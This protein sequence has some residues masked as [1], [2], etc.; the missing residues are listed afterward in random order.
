MKKEALRDLEK[1]L[2]D[3]PDNLGLRVTVA[4]ALREAGRVGDA[5]ELYR[6]VAIAYRD[7]GRVH[8]AVAVCRSILE[9][10][11]AD[12][13]CEALLEVLLD[14][15]SDRE[16][17][18]LT[19]LPVPMP[20]HVADP[21]T[22]LL[23][24]ISASELELPSRPSTRPDV[25][26]VT[27][28]EISR[29]TSRHVVHDDLAAELDTR[30]RPKSE[31]GQLAKISGPPPT[32]PVML[33][34]LGDDDLSGVPGDADDEKTIPRDAPGA[35]T[36]V[37]RSPFFAAIPVDRRRRVLE[38]F[39]RRTV[40]DGIP[41]IRTGETMHPLVIVERGV[42]EVR[43]DAGEPITLARI[44]AGDF[45]GEVS[46]MSRTPARTTLVT[47]TEADLLVLAARDF[48]ELASQYPALWKS[49]EHRHTSDTDSD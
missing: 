15:P 9:I 17:E 44:E 47:A 41:L 4:G 35:T 38:R 20:Y 10:A 7:Q 25:E 43:V 24:K 23:D 49:L 32:V 1:R 14:K 11:P 28:P 33:V 12:P 13:V 34:D 40:P 22:R 29:T 48:Y 21:T 6:S 45:Y 36:D 18:D 37:L 27:R 39:Q 2:R 42:L 30:R 19:P 16:L 5:V 26:E 8:Q 46:L 3:E 31:T